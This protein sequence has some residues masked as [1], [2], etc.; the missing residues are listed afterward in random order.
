MKNLFSREMSSK[1]ALLWGRIRS[2]GKSRF[3]LIYG[4]LLFGG[5]YCL[6]DVLISA[7]LRPEISLADYFLFTAAGG[8]VGGLIFG[9][10]NWRI[11]EWRYRNTRAANF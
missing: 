5:G 9:Y 3:L 7:V 4:V 2:K 8:V 1:E 10:L 11:L 6:L